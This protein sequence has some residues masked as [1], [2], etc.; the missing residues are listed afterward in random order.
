VGVNEYL[1][2][3]Q[4]AERARLARRARRVLPNERTFRTARTLLG[5]I[6]KRV[7]AA[8]GTPGCGSG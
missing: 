3:M 5:R 6:R 1:M 7:R 4:E 8:L 2:M